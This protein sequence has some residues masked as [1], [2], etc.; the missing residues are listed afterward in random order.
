MII[1]LYER[2]DDLKS[3]NIRLATENVVWKRQIEEIKNKKK[4]GK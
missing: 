4:K 1:S 3:N 2:I